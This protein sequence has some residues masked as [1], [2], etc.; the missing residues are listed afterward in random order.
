MYF[1]DSGSCPEQDCGFNY[2]G[3]KKPPDFE[4]QGAVMKEVILSVN[5]F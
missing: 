3:I 4:L 1:V 2:L 5:K